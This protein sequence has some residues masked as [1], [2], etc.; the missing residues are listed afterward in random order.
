MRV[1]DFRRA[2]ATNATGHALHILDAVSGQVAGGHK[3]QIVRVRIGQGAFRAKL[4]AEYGEVCALSGP[5]PAIALDACHLYSYAKVG[6]H[7]NDGGLLLRK[8]LHR[9]FDEG[10]ILVDPKSL[11]LLVHPDVRAFPAYAPLHETRLH[12]GLNVKQE[13]W[14]KLHLST[15]EQL[16]RHRRSH[17]LV[18]PLQPTSRLTA[19]C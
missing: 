5:V 11:S 1:D 10:R 19:R 8:D 3:Q 7:H 6:E 17:F 13:S 18:G 14:L 15:V 9:L 4:L 16:R 2:L 12:A